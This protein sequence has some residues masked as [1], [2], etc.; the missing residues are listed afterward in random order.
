MQEE[1]DFLG[2]VRYIAAVLL[3][4][5]KMSMGLVSG[6]AKFEPL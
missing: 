1:D 4:D 2:E 5:I 6:A 3:W